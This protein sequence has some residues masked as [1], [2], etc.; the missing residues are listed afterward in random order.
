[1][2]VQIG[3][4]MVS[5][6]QLQEVPS[7]NMILVV[8]PPGSGKSTFCEQAILQNLAIDKPIIY[9]TTEYDPSKAEASLR[10]KGLGKIEPGLISFVDAYNET[11]G[12]SV[13]ERP[14]TVYADC[15]DLSS[16]DIAISKLTEQLRRKGI[17]LIFD[18]LTSPYLFNGSEILRFMKQTLS[19]FAAKGNSVLACMDTGC[20]KEEDL[21]AM[22]SIADGI[23]KMDIKENS[24]VIDVVKHPIVAPAKIETPLTWSRMITVKFDPKFS[25]QLAETAFKG[26]G[27]QL[28]EVGDFVNVFWRSLIAWS[29][30]LWDPKRFPTMSYELVKE[31]EVTSSRETFKHLPW[32]M[33]LLVKFMPK[34]FSE[35]KNV[36]K[37]FPIELYQKWGIQVSEYL[38][39][40]SKKDEHHIKVQEGHCWGLEN[41]G[42]RLAFQD[43]GLLA[44]DV[45]VLE[46]EE[47]DW[48]AMEIKCVGLGDPYCELKFVPGEIPEMREFLEGI[49]SSIVEKIH[50]RLMD[51]LVAFLIKNRPLGDRPRLGRGF[52]FPMILFDTYPSLLSE[53]YRMALRMGGAKAGKEIG[54]H[55]M[56]E[57]IAEDQAVRRFIEFIEYCKVGKATLGETIRMKENCETF[58]LDTG[59]LSCF[60][61]TA[62]LNGFFSAVKNQHVKETKCIA[63]GDPYCE[64]EF[65]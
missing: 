19:K 38:E 65:R 34:N 2:G 23:I 45:K 57:G 17:L 43:C 15:N 33:K 62:F 26:S 4:N 42:A 8:G 20:G 29:G 52:A 31:L 36:K 3:D 11:V 64:W 56:N 12:I 41:V 24:R 35:V 44:A 18:S 46:K 37:V 40:A 21:G 6:A 7:K 47:R 51:Q 13:S 16:M 59:E 30:M 25:G 9:V 63:M 32:R 58:G 28:R 49:D 39:D 48:N 50:D 61:T 14:Y 5:L 22:M 60:F 54:E 53:R 10:E 1:M 55:L 27:K